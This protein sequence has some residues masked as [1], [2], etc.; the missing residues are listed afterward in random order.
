MAR[1]QPPPGSRLYMETQS[2][3][4][5]PRHR[6][7]SGHRLHRDEHRATFACTRREPTRITQPHTG[8]NPRGDDG[9]ALEER[10]DDRRPPIGRNATH[11]RATFE[12]DSR[13]RDGG[14]TQRG[15]RL[16]H[17]C[18]FTGCGRG[19]EEREQHARG[20]H[21][22][23]QGDHRPPLETPVGQEPTERIGNRQ[24]SVVRK[25]GGR[26]NARDA[27]EPSAG[28]SIPQRKDTSR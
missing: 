21:G 2:R 12:G 20:T 23:Y 22:A 28:L 7:R 18:P 10:G 14:S 4:R 16:N 26:D 13:F 17:R 3:L 11:D 5:G 15:A 19:G 25:G 1:C 9:G 24:P 27:L 8:R 6:P